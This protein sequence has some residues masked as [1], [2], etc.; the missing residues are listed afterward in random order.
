MTGFK[1][2]IGEFFVDLINRDKASSFA[3]EMVCCLPERGV[4]PVDIT[5]DSFSMEDVTAFFG[6][7][8][9]SVKV[10]PIEKNA[11]GSGEH[12]LV[13]EF[14]NKLSPEVEFVKISFDNIATDFDGDSFE[15]DFLDFEFVKPVI[16]QVTVFEGVA[17]ARDLKI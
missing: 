14:A 9:V 2:K 5:D 4:E 3:C 10:I 8:A 13:L 17:D 6:P 15:T 7:D 12:E 16:K 11:G 1:T